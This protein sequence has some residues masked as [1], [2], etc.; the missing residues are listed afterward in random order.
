MKKARI[1]MVLIFCVFICICTGILI[2]RHT[3]PRQI[4][5]MGTSNNSLSQSAEGSQVESTTAASSGILNINTA[6]QAQLQML[7]GIGETI[8][9]RIVDYRNSIGQ[10]H[11]LDELLMVEG[12][13]E[14]RLE[15]IRE[16][17]TV[18]GTK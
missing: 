18:G 4:R 2:G 13:G 12:I 7:P 1:V 16:Y 10:F 9:Q 8:A 11:S 15:Q 6:T 14:K 17:I 3:Q 5:I